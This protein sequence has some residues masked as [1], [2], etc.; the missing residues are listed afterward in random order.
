MKTPIIFFFVLIGS[1]IINSCQKDGK[2]QNKSSNNSNS[3]DTTQNIPPAPIVSITQT[4]LIILLPNNCQQTFT[5][6]NTGPQGSTL[7]YTVADDGALSGFLSFTNGT[8]SLSSGTSTTIMVSVKSSFVNGNPSLIGAS[9]VLDVYT[10]KASNYTKIPVPVNI[11]SIASIT[12]SLIGTWSG[13]WTG[14]S[15]GRNNPS[16]AQ[17]TSIVGGTWT[18]NVKTIDTIGMTATGS[19]TWDGTDAYWTYVF[20]TSGLITSATPVPFIPNRTIQF[21]ATNTTFSY[22]AVGSNCTS[23]HLTI[24]GFAN[25]PNPSD[26]FYG[27]LFSADFDISSNT[28]STTGVG[29]SAHPYAPVTFDTNVSSGT[30]SGTKQ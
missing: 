5:I 18:L 10:P 11:K 7:N 22:Q 1:L 23:L 30:V 15:F 16:Q 26:A 3:Q 14:N 13:T 17:P 9:L 2:G 19:L 20:D 12:S 4:P 25:Q 24:T 6:K 21:D 8:G 28:V 27:P 29:F